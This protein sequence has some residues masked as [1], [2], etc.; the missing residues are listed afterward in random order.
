M[1]QQSS[2]IITQQNLRRV[3]GLMWITSHISFHG[4]FV[5]Y[6]SVKEINYKNMLS[7]SLMQTLTAIQVTFV[8]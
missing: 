3:C 7:H 5:G 2:L 6:S 1:Q 8:Y 4:I